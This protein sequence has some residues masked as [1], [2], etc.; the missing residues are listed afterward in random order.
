MKKLKYLIT[1]MLAAVVF[2]F[3]AVTGIKV[4]AATVKI[5]DASTETADDRVQIY[6]SSAEMSTKTDVLSVKS[7]SSNV[8]AMVYSFDG[9]ARAARTVDNGTGFTFTAEKNITFTVVFAMTDNSKAYAVP[10]TVK[11]DGETDSTGTSSASEVTSLSFTL[12]KNQVLN[13]YNDTNKRRMALFEA[14]YTTVDVVTDEDASTNYNY[15]ESYNVDVS[16]LTGTEKVDGNYSQATA[17]D[18]QNFYVAYG[19]NGSGKINK[20]VNTAPT[21][22]A[23]QSSGPNYGLKFTTTKAASLIL[24]ICSTSGSNTSIFELA[25]LDE[26]NNI[27]SVLVANEDSS[28]TTNTDASTA[29]VYEV[30]GQTGTTVSYDLGIGTYFMQFISGTSNNHTK[31]NDVN[32]GGRWLDIKLSY[33]STATTLTAKLQRQVSTDKTAIRF[34]ATL[35]GFDATKLSKIESLTYT[36]KVTGYKAFNKNVTSVYTSITSGD[37]TIRAKKD[38]TYYCSYMFTGLLTEKNSKSL[39]GANIQAYLTIVVDGETITT[40][41]VGYNI[42]AAE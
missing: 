16:K 35:E 3:V 26:N 29:G 22:F 10:Y 7:L 36:I 42:V 11:I 41:S 27:T 32:R 19:S 30:S 39:V 31:D 15:V 6:A 13:I 17:D 9:Y 24:E 23:L 34:V 5:Y 8:Q 28:L 4:N 1:A 38:N 12:T 33:P 18:L 20:M 40:N 25:K 2:V 21:V 14:Y 37:D